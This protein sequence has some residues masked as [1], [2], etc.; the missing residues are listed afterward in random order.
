MRTGI[1]ET[2]D[3][4][5]CFLVE[6]EYREQAL[7]EAVEWGM[8]VDPLNYQLCISL[9]EESLSPFYP[10]REQRNS[11]LYHPF[12]DQETER[13][14]Y[15][16]RLH[17][18]CNRFNP[19]LGSH[20]LNNL[21]VLDSNLYPTISQTNIGVAAIYSD[22]IPQLQGAAQ[23]PQ[24]QNSGGVRKGSR[25]QDQNDNKPPLLPVGGG[26]NIY[27]DSPPKG[28]IKVSK[29]A[30]LV[31]GISESRDM[32]RKLSPGSSRQPPERQ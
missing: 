27:P 17:L 29:T 20:P 7:E 22:I 10:Y 32:Q 16:L 4:L 11:L 15:G 13:M 19:R 24:V 2:V 23:D 21:P 14:P 25:P 31:K 1:D 6:L 9:D 28:K 30:S 26:L 8:R 3:G 5:R 18:Q 12:P